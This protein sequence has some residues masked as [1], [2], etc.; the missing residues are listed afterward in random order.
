[1]DVCLVVTVHDVGLYARV[2]NRTLDYARASVV[3]VNDGSTDESASYFPSHVVYNLQDGTPEGVS[4]A[5]N[6]GIAQCPSKTRFVSWVD[7]DDWLDKDYV[8]ALRSALIRTGA[9][10]AISRYAG[11]TR[12]GSAQTTLPKSEQAF[13]IERA[14]AAN[15][16]AVCKPMPSTPSIAKLT[17]LNP[18]PGRRMYR[19]EHAPR[20]REGCVHYEDN[21]HWWDTLHRGG[22][23]AIVDRVLYHHRASR[24]LARRQH[25]AE[26]LWHA[27]T[28]SRH[29]RNHPLEPYVVSWTR[30]LSW[31]AVRQP[32]ARSKRIVKERLLDPTGYK[33]SISIVVPCHNVDSWI[34]SLMTQM[35]NFV[36]T[37]EVYGFTTQIIFIDALSTDSTVSKIR[38]FTDSRRHTQLLRYRRY[39]AWAGRVRNAA[40]P[41]IQGEFCLFLDADDVLQPNAWVNALRVAKLKSADLV[42]VRYDRLVESILSETLPSLWRSEPMFPPDRLIWQAN[43]NASPVNVAAAAKF[44]NYPWTRL[45]KTSLL[46]QNS[47]HFGVEAA[48][49]DVLFHWLTVVHATHIE[50]V[51]DIGIR[52]RFHA[53]KSQITTSKLFPRHTTIHYDLRLV[54]RRIAESPNWP[55]IKHTFSDFAHAVIGWIRNK[56]GLY[57]AKRVA[58]TTACI[59]RDSPHACIS[60]QPPT[61][62]APPAHQRGL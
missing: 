13:W 19:I 46:V 50:F 10:V 38:A 2:L 17:R 57:D 29:F 15:A 11:W 16:P 47:I 6:F 24:T 32:D 37:V 26:M 45:V 28:V 61:L 21:A 48:H 60:F 52:H 18:M 41:Y 33:Y 35:D 49:N 43:Y 22:S 51:H 7:G 1:M 14:S 44:I 58:F 4:Y 25:A 40:I 31:V 54:H 9:S 39:P 56:F 23:I 55:H 20:F 42:F 3:V 53:T 8:P 27:A 34:P 5:A 30:S 59:A 12:D 36:S 62:L